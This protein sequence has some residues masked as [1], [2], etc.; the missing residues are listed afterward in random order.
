MMGHQGR[1]RTCQS[2]QPHS[3]DLPGSENSRSKGQE[4]Q[5][6][7]KSWSSHIC[8]MRN[9][10]TYLSKSISDVSV[11]CSCKLQLNKALMIILLVHTCIAPLRFTKYF[12]FHFLTCPFKKPWQGSQQQ[13]SRISPQKRQQAW[14]ESVGGHASPQRL[15][16]PAAQPPDAPQH[17]VFPPMPW[18]IG[19][20]Q[21]DTG[22]REGVSDS[23]EMELRAWELL[24]RVPL[25]AVSPPPWGEHCACVHG[26][27]YL[28]SHY[29]EDSLEPSVC[30]T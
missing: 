25:R 8:G 16:S 14:L 30:A 27:L 19:V 7:G 17:S 21:R 11:S 2:E 29:P 3:E 24:I 20:L 9:I 18:K 10:D 4:A 15:W 28:T 26:R 1:L 5:Q 13:C 23:P 6:A 12:Y 22:S